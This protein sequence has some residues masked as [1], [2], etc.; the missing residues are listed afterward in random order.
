MKTAIKQLKVMYVYEIL[1]ESDKPLSRKEIATKL[2]TIYGIEETDKTLTEF[3]RNLMDADLITAEKKKRESNLRNKTGH[4]KTDTTIYTNY[5][6]KERPLKDKELLWLIDNAIFSKQLSET[7]SKNIVSKLLSLGSKVLKD[8]VKTLG[9]NKHFYHT[10]NNYISDNIDVLSTAIKDLKCVTFTPMEYG[11]DLKLHPAFDS[12]LFIKP[13]RLI[14]TNGFYYVIAFEPTSNT[15]QHY[16][17]DLMKDIVDSDEK[18]VCDDFNN[19]INIE[20][21]L[22]THSLMKSGV[23]EYAKIRM[24]EDKIGLAIDRFSTNIRCISDGDTDAIITLKSN[25]EDL[26]IWA[27]E[28]GEYVEVIE[29]QHIRNKLRKTVEAMHKVYSSEDLDRYYVALEKAKTPIMHLYRFGCPDFD[30]NLR[31]EWKTLENLNEIYIQNNKITDLSVICGLQNLRKVHIE[32]E[33]IKDISDLVELDRLRALA[34]CDTF[35]EDI[36]ILEH[37]NLRWLK[38]TGNYNIKDYSVLNK[39]KSLK[40]LYVDTDTLEQINVEEL[41]KNNPGLTIS[42]EHETDGVISI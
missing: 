2:K 23:A 26:Y 16:R 35:V 5:K 33:K 29:P 20:E 3:L 21:Y 11:I 40:M 27:L 14:S 42:H 25:S 8:K 22:S 15:L 19:K 17:I 7:E 9:D 1:L 6:L 10:S 37:I 30:L 31:H 36:S 13:L 24:P 32:N 12:N 39:I 4:E 34:L 28:N 38:L 18:V 41:K